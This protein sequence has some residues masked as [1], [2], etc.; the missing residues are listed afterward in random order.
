MYKKLLLV[1]SVVLMLGS[2]T[3]NDRA[4]SF[5]GTMTIEVPKGNRVTNITWKE[6]D[7][8]YSYRPYV[9]GEI[10]TTQTFIEESSMGIMEGK[11]IFKESN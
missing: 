5:G 4:K 7:L 10:P 2:C 11:V 9:N 6:G 3:E 1:L 8:W